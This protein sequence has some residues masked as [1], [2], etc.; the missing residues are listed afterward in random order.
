MIGVGIGIPFF[1]SFGGIDAQAQAHFNRVIAD[2]G[3]VP[4]GLSVVNAFFNTIKTIYGTSDINT[5][6]SVGLDPQVLGYK[7]GAGSG[8]TLGQAA[9]KLYSPKDVFGGIGTGNAYWEGSGVTGNFVETPNAAANQ[10]TG[11]IDIIA[12]VNFLSNSTQD[13]IVLK[14]NAVAGSSFCYSFFKDGNNI[15]FAYSNDG[16]VAARVTS[17]SSVTLSS[18]GY[19]YNT[20]IWVRVTRTVLNGDVKFYYGSDGINWTQLG[21]TQSTTAN[22]IASAAIPLRIGNWANILYFFTG[23]IYRVTISNSIGGAPVVDFNPNQ[24]T[25]ANIWTSTTSEVWTVNRTGAGLADVVQTT[26]ASQPLLL[27]HEGANYWFGSGV[28]GNYCS[29][30]NAA[31]NSN[32]G[33]KEFIYKVDFTVNSGAAQDAL[34]CKDNVGGGQR[35]YCH[36]YDGSDG[37]ITLNIATDLTAI[38]AYRSDLVGLNYVG[39]IKITFSFVAAVLTVS[40][41]K[42]VDGVSYTACGTNTISG[43]NLINTGAILELGSRVGSSAKCLGKIYRATISNSI[44]GAPV[45]DFNPNSYNAATSQTQW[46]SSTGEI[47]SVQTGTATTGYKGVLVDRTIVQSDGVDDKVSTTGIT[48][49]NN[50]TNYCAYKALVQD[51]SGNR[52]IYNN[53]TTNFVN[54]IVSLTTNTLFISLTNLIFGVAGTKVFQ[55]LGLSTSVFGT[56]NT[57]S[58]I[59]NG[60]FSTPLIGTYVGGAGISLFGAVTV[61]FGNHSINTMIVSVS[62][63]SATINTAMYNYIRSINNNAF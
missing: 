35:A 11:D 32:S 45:I 13:Q 36:F 17:S 62:D 51:S 39:Y 12:K 63:D 37:K 61:H 27:V 38:A 19:T 56:N 24:Y 41:F 5:A 20:D 59:N 47:W 46:T 30:P 60:S 16:T 25:G 53:G 26:A 29:T 23:K 22:S 8:T 52:I 54:A 28:T 49:F 58:K 6:I 43:N 34:F 48:L 9:Q 4:S 21:A 40:Y 10:I 42:S 3:L 50:H 14:A 15:K 55:T 7:L 57:K 1:K 33:N 18:V 2:G 31:A 44:G